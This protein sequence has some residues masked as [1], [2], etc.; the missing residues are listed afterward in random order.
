[1]D[2][3]VEEKNEDAKPAEKNMICENIKV[4]IDE[5]CSVNKEPNLSDI[6]NENHQFINNFENIVY[7]NEQLYDN[8]IS[9]IH[10]Y[11]NFILKELLYICEYYG[12]LKEIKSRKLNKCEIIEYIVFYETNPNNRDIVNKR[13]RLWFYL[14]ELKK[15]KF[16]KKFVFI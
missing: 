16:M 9:L 11:E 14:N 15:D 13:T 6:Y 7:R 8:Q 12:C 1:M 10:F 3:L 4:C 5:N 2:A